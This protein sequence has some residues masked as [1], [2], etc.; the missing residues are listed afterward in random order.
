MAVK[1]LADQL[2]A[3]TAKP[4]PKVEKCWLR[5]H[6]PNTSDLGAQMGINKL[7]LAVPSLLSNG[8]RGVQGLP[9][10]SKAFVNYLQILRGLDAAYGLCIQPQ[11][12]LVAREI[13]QACLHRLI[14]LHK[15]LVRLCH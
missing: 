7:R 14:E 11:K 15:Y 10:W 4:I 9:A 6:S 1:R 3:D 5:L 13:V 2:Q 8:V 12:R